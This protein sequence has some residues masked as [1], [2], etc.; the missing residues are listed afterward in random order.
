MLVVWV[1]VVIFLC[2]GWYI[3]AV[4]VLGAGK[5]GCFM[6]VWVFGHVEVLGF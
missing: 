3:E 2:A 6:V 4:D 1:E 5:V